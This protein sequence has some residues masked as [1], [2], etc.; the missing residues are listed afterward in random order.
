MNQTV[1]ITGHLPGNLRDDLIARGFAVIEQPMIRTEAIA[2][3]PMLPA[4]NWIFFSSRNAVRFFYAAQ[5]VI[6]DHQLAAIGKGT[7]L[8]LEKYGQCSFA[9]ESNDTQ[10]VAKQFVSIAGDSLVLF[11]QS[12]ESLRTIQSLLKPSQIIDLLCYKT[13]PSPVKIAPSDILIF[14]SPSNVVAFFEMNTIAESQKII[15]YG[16]STAH[17]LQKQGVE[18]LQI[19]DSLETNILFDTIIR[20][21]RS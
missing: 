5:P 6:T 13:I 10:A 11:P 2:F 17:A 16:S 19:P 9:G 21:S 15:A 14:T 8:E 12:S 18:R 3:D 7:A 20:C 4:C 1:L